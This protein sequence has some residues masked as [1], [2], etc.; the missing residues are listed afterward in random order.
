MCSRFVLKSPSQALA[1][2]F[3]LEKAV[4]WE[5]SYNVAPSQKIPAVVR[6]LENK[7]REMKLLQWGFV[8]SW[9]QGGRLLINVQSENIGDKPILE[10][11]F[12]KWR[13][14]I[15]VDGF[16]EWRHQAKETRPFYFQMKDK[17]PFALAGLWAPQKV[18]DKVIEVC[19]ILTTTPNEEVRV[20]HD[21][22]PVILD[23]KHYDLWLES[24][25]V[26]DF[27]EI[28]QLF[29]PYPGE[30]MEGYQVGNWVNNVMHN[31]PKCMEPS[32]E[33]ETISFDFK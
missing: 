22:M 8:A 14:L 20:V 33:P 5:P 24:D 1:S 31:D 26:R 29:R 12:E 21:R 2:M 11:S 25:D 16:Y 32:N 19:A 9:N 28:N 27:K 13:C 18:E 7:K 4:D 3:K 15:P 6:P 23:P 30:K 17:K 10:E